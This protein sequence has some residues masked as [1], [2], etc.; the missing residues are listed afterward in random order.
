MTHGVLL[1]QLAII[2][3]FARLCGAIARALRQPE[4]IG[5]MSAGV[6]L[7]PIVLGRLWP[8]AHAHLFAKTSLAPLSSLATLGVVLFLF[9]VGL[10]LRTPDGVRAQL[11]A[12]GKVGLLSMGVPL[13]LGLGISPWLFAH[14]AP[15]GVGF[16]P[17]GLFVAAR[18]SSSMAPRDFVSK[19]F[20]SAPFRAA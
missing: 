8:A 15:P 14:L 5:E 6:L 13:L 7:G 17:F 20:S 12:A 10:E 4:V 9:L 18:H 2:L 19:V 16:W 3:L 1:L 11:S